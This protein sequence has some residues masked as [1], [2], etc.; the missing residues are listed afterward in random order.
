M[1]V[2]SVLEIGVIL[3]SF[4]GFIIFGWSFFQ[5]FLF[6]DYEVKHVWV[7]FHFSIVFAISASMYELVILE[8]LN[9]SE[10][11]YVCLFIYLFLII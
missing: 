10:R 1:G 5:W 6:K 11:E 4:L 8:I 9:F 2:G 3:A 7:P